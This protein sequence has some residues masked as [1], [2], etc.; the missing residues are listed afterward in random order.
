LLLLLLQLLLL[1]HNYSKLDWLAPQSKLLES[2]SAGPSTGQ[3]PTSSIKALQSKIK[4]INLCNSA[5]KK[6]KTLF[7]SFDK[8][9]LLKNEN[10]E[11]AC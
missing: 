10:M 3:M 2:V 5:A 6:L 11:C 9:K 4:I 8:M 7:L 1:L